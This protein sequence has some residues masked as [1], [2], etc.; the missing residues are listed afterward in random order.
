MGARVDLRW[1]ERIGDSD[2]AI[3]PDR[4]RAGLMIAS[5]RKRGIS[6]TSF[7]TVSLFTRI[8]GSSRPG[9]GA[10]R[11]KAVLSLA[12]SRRRRLSR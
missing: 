12:V 2:R 8:L 1:E 4:A 3:G 5:A 11:G 6:T 7:L 10:R 9:E